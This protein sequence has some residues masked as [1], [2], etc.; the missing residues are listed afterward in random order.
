MAHI[1]CYAQ[2]F[3]DCE[4]KGKCDQV[5]CLIPVSGTCPGCTQEL[6]WGDLVRQRQYTLQEDLNVG[7]GEDS[8]DDELLMSQQS[9]CEDDEEDFE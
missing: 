1:S 7:D 8:G 2:H 6:L 9:D 5:P 3:L 4:N